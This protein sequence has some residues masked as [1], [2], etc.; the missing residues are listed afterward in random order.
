MRVAWPRAVR[1]MAPR[2][3]D[4]GWFEMSEQARMPHADTDVV[5]DEYDTIIIGAGF[6]GLYM[7]HQVRQLGLSTVVLEQAPD[8]GGTWYWNAYPGARCDAESLIYN[9]AFDAELRQEYQ[10]KWPEKY[11]RQPVILDYARHVADRFDL[12]RDIRF[13]TRVTKA[14]WDEQARQWLV[15]ADHAIF[16]GNAAYRALLPA[17]AVADLD[18]PENASWLGPERHFVHYWLRG[19]E[20]LNVVTVVGST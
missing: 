6:A 3:S 13:D 9:Y 2:T 11:S 12:R 15:G 19:G 18:L 8:V 16:S 20:V 17:E 14:V 4:E 1:H 5:A 7:L 10:Y